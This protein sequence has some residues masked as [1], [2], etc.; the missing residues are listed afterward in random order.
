MKEYLKIR[1]GLY[2]DLEDFYEKV[3]V[4]RNVNTISELPVE[5]VVIEE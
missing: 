3:C 4:P 2:I 1:D 5:E